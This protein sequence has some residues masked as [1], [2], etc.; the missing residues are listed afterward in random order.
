MTTP[1]GPTLESVQATLAELQTKYKALEDNLKLE[2]TAKG[3]LAE[4]V[5]GYETSGAQLQAQLAALTTEHTTTK[6]KHEALENQHIQ[7]RRE[8]LVKHHGVQPEVVKD[9]SAT[10]LEALEKTLPAVKSVVAP[11]K[12]G[13][14][15]GGAGGA[16]APKTAADVIQLAMDR[17]AG[18]K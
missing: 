12:N 13:Y 4:K 2:Q 18:K 7:F 14:G 15:A 16:T 10:Q 8:I 11:E 17:A 1:N 5:K 6:T 9:F 3:A